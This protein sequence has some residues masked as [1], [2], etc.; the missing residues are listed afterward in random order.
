[1]RGRDRNRSKAT[2]AEYVA[3]PA[4]KCALLALPV[5]RKNHSN[6][7]LIMVSGLAQVWSYKVMGSRHLD[8]R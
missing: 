6:P 8:K 5:L 7:V 1:M 4:S 3:H 2:C